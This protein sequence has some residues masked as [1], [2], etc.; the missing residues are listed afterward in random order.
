VLITEKLSRV[1]GVEAGGS[2]SVTLS[3]GRTYTVG[4]TGVVDNYILHYI[5]MSPDV[6]GD[7]FGA[8]PNPNSAFVF[9][10]DGRDFAA[11]LLENSDARAIVYNDELKARISD[12]TDALGVVTVVLIVLACALAFVVLFNLTY[13][14][15]S[16]RVRELATIKVL[17]FHDTELAMY[18]YRENA[19]VTLLG[20]VLG[21]IGGVFLFDYVIASVEID[22]L[23]FP[24]T[25]YLRNYVI[26][27]ALSVVFAVFVNL[28]MSFK[29]ARIDMVESLK[30]VE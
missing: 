29:L 4:V 20:I 25:L 7:V 10:D 12:S 6:Y 23:K 8:A 17:G 16:E 3:D 2:L 11:K 18:V 26:A 5:Y 1:A 9:C 21:L 22:V 30:N 24:K 15:I 13:I 19:V 14:N 27:A 28:V